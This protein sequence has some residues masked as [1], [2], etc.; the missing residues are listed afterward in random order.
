MGDPW[1]NCG[2]L[3]R[4]YRTGRS[5]FPLA[6][7]EILGTRST[8]KAR[9]AAS[10]SSRRLLAWSGALRSRGGIFVRATDR[11]ERRIPKLKQQAKTINLELA[12][13]EER[14]S[15]KSQDSGFPNS[16][17]WVRKR[18]Q[19]YSSL[20]PSVEEAWRRP[21]SICLSWRVDIHIL[22]PR[23]KPGRQARLVERSIIFYWER[24]LKRPAVSIEVSAKVGELLFDER[25]DRKTRRPARKYETRNVDHSDCLFGGVGLV[26]EQSWDRAPGP[27]QAE[28]PEDTGTMSVDSQ[29]RGHPSLSWLLWRSWSCHGMKLRLCPRTCPSWNI[30]RYW[31]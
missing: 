6:R 5:L 1:V 22:L 13:N 26:T 10:R 28:T 7:G 11:T 29:K 30:W 19:H 25:H 31:H 27:V 17:G 9:R 4:S 20:L 12:E 23:C 16:K 8:R 2:T 14:P 21:P 18:W 24:D 3:Y 15:H